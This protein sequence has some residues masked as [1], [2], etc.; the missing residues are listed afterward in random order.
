MYLAFDPGDTTGWA[1][2]DDEGNVIEK[3]QLNLEEL[4]DKCREWRS[5]PIKVVIYEDFRIFRHKAQKFAG[6][7]MVVS[8]T[9]GIILSMAREAGA[10]V[11]SQPSSIKP[12][13]EKWTQVKPRG[14]HSQSHEI[15][16]YNHGKYYLIGEGICKS[17]LEEELGK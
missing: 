8:Q 5:A 7:K 10:K 6:N 13:A 1:S 4:M 2:F 17:A 9:I 3:G 15:D 16:A 11:V 14:P 12:I